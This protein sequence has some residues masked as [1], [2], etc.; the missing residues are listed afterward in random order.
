MNRV[1]IKCT[2]D[3]A[4]GDYKILKNRTMQ[5]IH[6]Y[7]KRNVFLALFFIFFAEYSSALLKIN[8]SYSSS[9]ITLTWNSQGSGAAVKVYRRTLGTTGSWT[10]KSTVTDPSVSYTDNTI[11]S[12]TTYEYK[13]ESQVNVGQSDNYTS[14]ICAG[15]NIPLVETRGTI[16][17]VV[18]NTITSALSSE[19]LRLEQDLRGDGW[20]VVRYDSPRHGSGT[21]ATLKAWIKSQYTASPTTV[22]SLM[23]F[24]HLPVCL[25][26]GEAPD[27]HEVVALPADTYYGDMDGTWT[28]TQNFTGINNVISPNVAGDGIYDQNYI[29][30]NGKIELQVGRVDLSGMTAFSQSEVELLRNYLNKDHNWRHSILK[31]QMKGLAGNR[32]NT[33]PGNIY[34]PVETSCL[35]S[36]FGTSNVVEGSFETAN[37]NSYAWAV[38]F[39][40]YNGANYP[41]YHYKT[42]FNINF[43]SHKQKFQNEN[44]AMRGLLCDPDYGLTVAWGSRPNAFFHQMGTGQTIGYSTMRSQSNG[45]ADYSPNCNYWFGGGVWSNLLGDPT[46][47][48]QIVAPPTNLTATTIASSVNLSWTAS[49]DA[50]IGYHVYR[51]TSE[52]GTY[53][54][55]TTNP[56]TATNYT[57]ASPGATVF[58]RVHAVKLEQVISG[59]FFNMSQ[60]IFV[61]NP[62]NP[63]ADTQAPTSPA[64]L[65]ASNFG[66]TNFTLSWTASTDNIAVTSYEIF[67]SGVSI[68]SSTTNSFSVTGLT[69]NTS[70]TFTVK[71]KDAANN[72]SVVSA[73]FTT[74]IDA[75]APTAP[76]G[77]SA[78]AKTSTGFT[79]TWVGSTD[80]IAVTRYDVYLNNVF[81][82]ST[83]KPDYSTA[84]PTTLP[85][86][87]LTAATAYSLQVKA[88]DA[89][90]NA[91]A[92]SSTLSVITYPVGAITNTLNPVADSDTGH[93]T[94]LGTQAT[95]Y[96]GAASS[97]MLFRFNMSAITTGVFSAKFRVYQAFAKTPYTM[98]VHNTSNETWVEGGA[99]PTVGSLITSVPVSGALGY[100]EIDLTAFVKT[101]LAGS[102]IVSIMISNNYGSDF[103]F[104]SRENPSYKPELLLM[105]TATPD[106]QAPSLPAGLS[107]S[108]VSTSTFTLNWNASTD[109]TGVDFYEV[110]KGG[111]SIG[112]TA[113][114]TFIVTGLTAPVTYSMTVKATDLLGNVTAASVALPVTTVVD[115]T[116]P[117]VPSSLS[118]SSV[119]TTSFTLNWAASTDNVA[120]SGY[121]VY[122]DG[123]LFGSSATN[124]LAITGLVSGK[125]YSMTVKAKDAVGNISSSSSILRVQTV[126]AST[127][128]TLN[129]T[130]DMDDRSSTA[131]SLYCGA[132]TTAINFKFN[133]SSVEGI[134]SSAK[135]RLYQAFARNAAYTLSVYNASNDTWVEGGTKPTK[136]AL[137]GQTTTVLTSGSVAPGYVEVDL[138]SLIQ[139]EMSL[140]K[141][142]S[143]VVS[144]NFGSDYSSYSRESATN[145]PQL[146]IVTDPDTQAPTAPLNLVSSNKTVDSFLLSWTASSDNVGVTGY[147][148]YDNNVLYASTTTTSLQ[149]S[150]L[151]DAHHYMTVIAKD[152]F[153]N[154]STASSSLWVPIGLI[155][156]L[157]DTKLTNLSIFPNPV[158]DVLHIKI[159][160][161]A[162]A[163]VTITDINGQVVWN[164]SQSILENGEL[165]L[166]SLTLRSGIY[167]ISVK[168]N[169]GVLNAK[170]SVK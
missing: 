78:S 22:K 28:D 91:S 166:R 95:V 167:V 147:D 7:K 161:N 17:L 6:T 102:K 20:T 48:L 52:T 45:D 98:N 19:L 121:D 97:Y 66:V 38:D 62:L 50:S 24:G 141:I 99:L 114:T 58:Y 79:L 134:P 89:M 101:K 55:V 61:Q 142:V 25:S 82:G 144:S 110:F 72:V 129:P 151:P 14:Y 131:T 90:G 104:N 162:V 31:A 126:I 106:T 130:D 65:T 149:L 115:A 160:S 10:L 5:L 2:L 136:G 36:L 154:N 133:I 156:S 46:L 59:T 157:D 118:S 75:Q 49:A 140:N 51:A 81:Y 170:F 165:V 35:Y 74:L 30:G 40:D 96:S 122:K 56:I 32:L 9:S 53:T 73:T 42:I 85:V 113:N 87:G 103:S 117:S 60:G 128:T 145:K 34:L 76:T 27:G 112:T 70:Y 100:V 92:L 86:S 116:A 47:R 138:T 83:V 94:S 108:A 150:Y 152:G 111:V 146:V 16:L 93:D 127:T 153:G 159:N 8:A 71:A 107:A 23:L 163:F 169:T 120:V 124:S 88:I 18:D 67:K 3:A 33:S 57:D 125:T 4:L 69:P 80:N 41:G 21:P 135:F 139:S 168:D 68:G 11:V 63:V 1:L 132:P 29:P 155:T 123:V 12:G 44:N 137:V 64:Q 105:S 143:I 148:L 15:V 158:S 119:L 13:V 54:R 109:N 84:L 164:E 77:L 37:T 26:G 43:G 39:G